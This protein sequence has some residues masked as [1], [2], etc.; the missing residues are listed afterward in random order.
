MQALVKY[1]WP[2]NVRELENVIERAVALESTPTVLAERLPGTLTS[3]LHARAAE[4]APGFDLDRYLFA[5]EADLL[6]KALEQ[7]AGDRSRAA[8]I[9]G[10]KPRSLRYLIRKHGVGAPGANK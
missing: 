7:A 1:S 2:G 4:L 9:L 5:L 10:I 6:S 8:A 3:D